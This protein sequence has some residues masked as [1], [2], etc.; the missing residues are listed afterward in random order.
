MEWLQQDR[1]FTAL[2]YWD[3]IQSS[4]QSIWYLSGGVKNALFSNNQN[5]LSEAERMGDSLKSKNI[6]IVLDTSATNTAENFRNFF[7]YVS[8]LEDSHS[9]LEIIIVTSRFHQA[10]AE[11]FF[12]GFF[13]QSSEFKLRWVLGLKECPTCAQDELFHMNNVEADISKALA[14]A[15]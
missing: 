14:E 5:T 4:E 11:K 6:N 13:P 3:S 1:I 7:K 10:R 15:N 12:Y 8:S 2:Q 9:N